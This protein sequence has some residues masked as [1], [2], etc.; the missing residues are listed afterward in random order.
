MFYPWGAPPDW[1]YRRSN[2]VYWSDIPDGQRVAAEK[3]LTA[4]CM[5]NKGYELVSI[6]RTES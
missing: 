4:F 5:H 3:Q 1:F 6:P 2:W